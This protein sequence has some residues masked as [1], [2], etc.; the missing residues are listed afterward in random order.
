MLTAYRPVLTAPNVWPF[1]LGGVLARTGGAMFGVAVIVMLSQRRGSYT[2]AGAVSAVG[3]LVLAIAGPFI[4]RL[5]DKHGQRRAA[6]P[7]VLLSVSG[8]L[9]TV[10]LSAT[11]AP[12]GAIFV[13]YALSAV[14][15]ELGPMSRA[16]WAHIFRDRPDR[17][18]TA[19]SFEQ[20]LDEGAFVLGPVL[21]VLLAT[22]WFPEAGLLGASILF[23]AG[24]VTFLFAQRTEP[25][26]TDREHRPPGLAIRH[27]GLL[28]VAVVLV[29][30][31]VI[32]GA[33][34]VVAVAVA[35]EA[36]RPRMSSM[37]LAS[38]ALGS[39]ITG[40]VFGAITFRISQTRRLLYAALGM[41]VLEAPALVVGELW[42]LWG[43]VLVMLVAGCATAPMLITAM[44]L[45]QHLVPRPLMTEGMAIA[46]TG[47]LI[48]I[49]LGAAVGGI[50][51]DYL[52]AH[53]AY[54]VPVTAGLV[55][56]LLA[57]AR[58]RPLLRAEQEAVRT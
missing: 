30:T 3:I 49:S 34:E 53:A 1:V 38:F 5:A 9:V 2:L 52:G 56:V 24:M 15:P 8:A 26:V 18:H 33:N 40:I 31:G 43:L 28:P 6:L 41:F 19:M 51:V 17:L 29:M 37:I 57:G 20:V 23:G 48:G 45:S 32:F 7:F 47:I 25:P 13:A 14:T 54:V 50:A 55:A 46:V 44:S 39:T 10:Y 58:Y 35:D 22:T 42:N 21:A 12:I 11:M 36:G 4:G 16:R 27:A